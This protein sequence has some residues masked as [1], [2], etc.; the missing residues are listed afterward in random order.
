MLVEGR[1]LRASLAELAGEVAV[2]AHGIHGP[3]SISWRVGGEGLVF[4]GAARAALLQLAHPAV[5]YAI[6]QHS[7][8]RRDARAR[9][10]RTFDNIFA[11]VFGDLDAAVRAAR[12]VHAV[13]TRIRGEL[14]EDAGRHRRGDRYQANESSALLWV[15]ATLIDTVYAV[16]ELVGWPLSA[17]EREGYYRESRRFAKLFGIPAGEL[18]ADAAALAAYLERAVAEGEV[19]VTAPARQMA[20]FLLAPPHPAL[21]PVF[22]WYRAVTAALLPEPLGRDFGLRCTPAQAAAVTASC[23]SLGA[24]WRT[25]PPGLRRIP[26]YQAAL[27]RLGLARETTA[28][29]AV[30]YAVDRGL[31]LWA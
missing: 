1:D 19:A 23:R 24:V 11:M 22:G 29:R 12:R 28:S 30:A 9:F 6:E 16:R 2:P 20:R 27:E 10:R 26:E 3:G 5:A 13:H 4:L 14:G 21:A 7:I 18:P 15:H 25:L 17:D 31:A 8:T